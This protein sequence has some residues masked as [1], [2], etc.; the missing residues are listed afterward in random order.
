MQQMDDYDDDDGDAC[1]GRK[2]IDL[3]FFPTSLSVH[4]VLRLFGRR[5]LLIIR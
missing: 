4:N 5:K 2:T 3:K 1:G